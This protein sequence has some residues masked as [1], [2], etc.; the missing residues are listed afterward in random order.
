MAET[1]I[2][3]GNYTINI[4]RYCTW[5]TERKVGKNGKE[6]DKRVTGYY[7]TLEEVLEDFISKSKAEDCTTVV[8]VINEIKKAE[9]QAIK[10]AKAYLNEYQKIASSKQRGLIK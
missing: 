6:Y 1:K 2:K 8:E 4:D 3:A 7:R 5:V 10:I 9:D